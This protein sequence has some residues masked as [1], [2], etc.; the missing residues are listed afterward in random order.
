MPR[1]LAGSASAETS[2]TVRFAQPASCCH[3]G[4]GSSVEHPLPAPDQVFSVQPRAVLAAL[5]SV[6]PPT[7][8][9]YWEDAGQLTPNPESP[10]D[11]VTAIPGWFRCVSAARIV[12]SSGPP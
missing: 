12:L 8:V 6:V 3:A 9:T 11:A 7:A 10:E 4:F 2:A 5:V 1:P